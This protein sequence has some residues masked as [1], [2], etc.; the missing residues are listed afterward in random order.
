MAKVQMNVWVEREDREALKA[1][2]AARG[3]SLGELVRE[4]AA[5]LRPVGERS[6]AVPEDYGRLWETVDSHE[7]R[8]S[9]LEEMAGF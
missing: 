7:S 3:V 1:A 6:V 8:L 9:R 2:A 5:K 4:V